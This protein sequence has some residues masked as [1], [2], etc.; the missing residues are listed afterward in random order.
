MW[1]GVLVV[2]LLE[3]LCYVPVALLGYHIFGN[4]LITLETPEC[5]VIAANIFVVLHVIGS[6]RF[7]LC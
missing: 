3:A 7:A 6:Y 1:R 5:L 4:I 2:Y